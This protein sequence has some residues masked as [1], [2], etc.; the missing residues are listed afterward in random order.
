MNSD[1]VHSLRVENDKTTEQ[2]DTG[3]VLAPKYQLDVNKVNRYIE[4]AVSL[5]LEIMFNDSNQNVKK[6]SAL[7]LQELNQGKAIYDWVILNIQTKNYIRQITALQ[8]LRQFAIIAKQDLGILAQTLQDPFWSVRIEAC[9]LCFALGSDSPV[10][11]SGLLDL[12]D[13][14]HTKVR[15]EAIRGLI[16]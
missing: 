2:V 8:S 16:M 14:T 7:A 13:D 1:I 12:L 6:E 11:V 15:Q 5:M 3:P 4:R 9:K 10:L